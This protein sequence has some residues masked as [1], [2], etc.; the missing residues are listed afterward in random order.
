MITL[1]VVMTHASHI[2]DEEVNVKLVALQPRAHLNAPRICVA[3][4]AAAKALQSKKA[5]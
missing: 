2:R 5:E 3:S 4:A 1:M